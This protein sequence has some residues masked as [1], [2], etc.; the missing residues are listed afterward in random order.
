MLAIELKKA[1]KTEW[2]KSLSTYLKNQYSA[3]A[4]EEYKESVNLVQQLRD[5]LTRIQD[6][7]ETCKELYLR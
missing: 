6:K 1:E 4:L 5:D 3:N 2:A 7:N